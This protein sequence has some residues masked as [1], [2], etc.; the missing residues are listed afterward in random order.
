MDK[1]TWR[2][3]NKQWCPLQAFPSPCL[4]LLGEAFLLDLPEKRICGEEQIPRDKWAAPKHQ[5]CFNPLQEC[6]SQEAEEACVQCSCF[7]FLRLCSCWSWLKL[8]LI[9]A[10]G[11]VSALFRGFISLH[12]KVSPKSGW[13]HSPNQLITAE[14]H[15]HHSKLQDLWEW[16]LSF[17]RQKH[18]QTHKQDSLPMIQTYFS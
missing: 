11:W 10:P 6:T 15:I 12:L 9:S 13:V 17:W 4:H 18:L 16:I 1:V 14:C 8:C 5:I 2:W 7:V 3:A